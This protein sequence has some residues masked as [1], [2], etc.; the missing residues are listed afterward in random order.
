MER[1]RKQTWFPKTKKKLAVVLAWKFQEM[2]LNCKGK[3][4]MIGQFLFSH[5]DSQAIS[6]VNSDS[7]QQ[8]WF[9]FLPSSLPSLQYFI[10]A[11]SPPCFSIHRLKFASSCNWNERIDEKSEGKEGKKGNENLSA[12]QS[13]HCVI[14]GV[15]RVRTF[16]NSNSNSNSNTIVEP[17]LFFFFLK[18][19]LM[20]RNDGKRWKWWK[21]SKEGKRR[22][23]KDDHKDS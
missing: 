2:G 20:R 17:T 18:K 15:G 12:L 7:R 16:G 21:R 9:S 11:L 14:K 19:E 1:S 4:W 13:F 3:V 8:F 23:K 22:K 6:H 5:L 10:I